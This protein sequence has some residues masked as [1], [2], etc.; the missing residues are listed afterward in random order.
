[1]VSFV[2]PD[3]LKLTLIVHSVQ[4]ILV[5]IPYFI[6]NSTTAAMVWEE[7]HVCSRLQEQND[8]RT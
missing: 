3:D 5:S 8:I 4:T 2:T 7:V 1:M 6:L